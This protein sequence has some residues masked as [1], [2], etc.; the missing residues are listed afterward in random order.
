MWFLSVTNNVNLHQTPLTQPPLSR[1]TAEVF[2]MRS[3]FLSLAVPLRLSQSDQRCCNWHWLSVSSISTTGRQIPSPLRSPQLLS[4]PQAPL[5]PPRPQRC[6]IHYLHSGFLRPHG[7]GWPTPFG[8]CPL[9]FVTHILAD[10]QIYINNCTGFKHT[11]THVGAR[12]WL[13]PCSP[14]S[15]SCLL[16]C[17]WL[18]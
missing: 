13:Q 16:A 7:R 15:I 12:K 8:L 3:V 17:S 9:A 4:C 5:G 1:D 6:H 11:R 2:G 14:F 18:L 10:F